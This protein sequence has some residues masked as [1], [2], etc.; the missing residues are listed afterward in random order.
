MLSQTM[1][2]I[3]GMPTGPRVSLIFARDDS[4]RTLEGRVTFEVG[5]TL[6]QRIAHQGL[7]QRQIRAK[8]PRRDPFPTFSAKMKC[9]T[10]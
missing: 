3:R 5:E 6:T 4:G 7:I 2:R 1:F 8:P 10:F 9:F